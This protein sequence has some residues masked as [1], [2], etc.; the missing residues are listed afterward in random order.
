M[1]LR[2]VFIYTLANPI[3]KEIFYVGITKSPHKRFLA[4]KYRLGFTPIMEELETVKVCVTNT[5]L[6]AE[7]FW[8]RQLAAWGFKLENKNGL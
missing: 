1:T 5:K 8:I 7:Y 2:E 4:H 6:D 3:T